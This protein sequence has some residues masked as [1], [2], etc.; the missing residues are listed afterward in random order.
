MHLLLIRHAQS[1]VNLDD[2]GGG[3]IDIGLTPLGQRQAESLGQWLADNA[4]LDALYVSTMARTLETAEYV[5]KATGHTPVADDRIREFGNCYADGSPVPK[6]KMPIQYAEFWST[7]RPYNR[8]CADG[9]SWM[10]FRARVGLFVE[11]VLRAHANGD[12]DTSVGVI[13]HGGVIDA[14]FDYAFNVGPYRRVELWTHNTGVV[15][16][17]YVP[18]SGREVWRLHAHGMVN[19]LVTCDGEWLGSMPM[20]Y[21][22]TRKV[23]GPAVKPTIEEQPNTAPGT[24]SPP[25]SS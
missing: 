11:D 5:C 15:H 1:Y 12:P 16:F 21:D 6:E 17:E 9:E 23:I 7:E 4:R 3:Y 24:K 2:W 22:A 10:L 14:V 25:E 20:L 19:H 18:D 8:I 13:C